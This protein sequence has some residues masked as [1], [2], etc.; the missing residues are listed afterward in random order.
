MRTPIPLLFIATILMFGCN[1]AETYSS[2]DAE[3]GIS[4]HVIN[5]DSSAL[6]DIYVFA[7]E[8]GI[9]TDSCKTNEE[10]YFY[11]GGKCSGNS[12]YWLTVRDFRPDSVPHYEGDSVRVVLD[13]R[14]GNGRANLGYGTASINLI[15]K[16]VIPEEKETEETVK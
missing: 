3:Y 11:I 14:G 6:K 2:V 9:L 16:W 1:G 7:W 10:G 8:E 13:Y 15:M 5:L 4:G 12:F